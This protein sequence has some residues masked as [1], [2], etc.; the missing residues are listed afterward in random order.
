MIRFCYV[1]ALL[2]VGC[3]GSR[4][5]AQQIT[6][7]DDHYPGEDSLAL[8]YGKSSDGEFSYLCSGAFVALDDRRIEHP[9]VITAAHCFAEAGP[10]IQGFY[11][12]FDAGKHCLKLGRSWIGDR[13]SGA[14]IAYSEMDPQET[15]NIG[16]LKPSPVSLRPAAPIA[17]D[18]VWVG[19]NPDNQGQALSIGYV[20]NP[21]YQQP[22]I[23][24]EMGGK[25]VK[26]D[27]RGYVVADINIAPG[28][29]GSLLL[30]KKGAVGVLSG[31][32]RHDGGFKTTFVTP[33][34]RLKPVLLQTESKIQ[35]SWEW[36]TSPPALHDAPRNAGNIESRKSVRAPSVCWLL[37]SGCTGRARGG[38]GCCCYGFRQ[39]LGSL[40]VLGVLRA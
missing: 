37:A 32:F 38:P 18:T 12:S 33:I 6:A 9:R 8:I 24:G 36:Q 29:S 4:P 28:S 19:G 25:D 34:A 22:P 5:D 23:S 16:T 15:E 10:D 21:D 27:H 11:A 40:I 7:S 30:S 14:D 17:G 1:A 31:D 26:L 3:T 39:R 35:T 13:F 2:L 20:M